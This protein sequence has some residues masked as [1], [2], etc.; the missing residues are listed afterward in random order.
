VGFRQGAI[1]L[2]VEAGDVGADGRKIGFELG[3]DLCAVLG[4]NRLGEVG[5]GV[6]CGRV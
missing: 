3:R 2:C 4:E 5:D 1:A 6:V